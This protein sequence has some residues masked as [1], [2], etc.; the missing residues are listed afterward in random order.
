[1]RDYINLTSGLELSPQFPEARLVRIQ[2]SHLEAVALWNVIADLDYG[3]LIDAA[4]V[5]CNVIDCGSRR[6]QLARAQWQG[7]PWIAFAYHRANLH[8]NQ[9]FPLESV[10]VCKANCAEHFAKIFHAG[11]KLRDMCVKKLRYVGKVTGSDRL[12]FSTYAGRSTL[13][14]QY[15]KLREILVNK[16]HG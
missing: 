10:M 5:G 1:M 3:F 4:T 14:G 6:G 15:D 7:L 12:S 13:D 8:C 2:S 16:Q 9:S 11:H